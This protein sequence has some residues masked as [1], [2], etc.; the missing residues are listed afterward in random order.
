MAS[1]PRAE[2][3]SAAEGPRRLIE[4]DLLNCTTCGAI[5]KIL[6]S[7][8]NAPISPNQLNP[9]QIK[10]CK[11]CHNFPSNLLLQK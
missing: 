11:P 3:P 2:I 10:S 7:P 4:R 5:S 6:S 9:L 1:E 8:L